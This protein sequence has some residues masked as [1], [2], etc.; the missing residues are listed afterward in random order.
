[1][2]KNECS[3][4]IFFLFFFIS[5]FFFLF[6]DSTECLAA[7]QGFFI[8]QNQK[9]QLI[10]EAVPITVFTNEDKII[11]PGNYGSSKFVVQNNNKESV[12]YE[13][14]VAT[15]SSEDI[16]LPLQFT[17]KAKNK[18]WFLPVSE[19]NDSKRELSIKRT[20]L[21][22][23]SE[24]F[25]LSWQWLNDDLH[26]QQIQKIVVNKEL[27]GIFSFK[28]IAERNKKDQAESENSNKKELT[29]RSDLTTD[30]HQQVS[31]D[32]VKP[33]K[34]RIF[35]RLGEYVYDPFAIILCILL[36]SCYWFRKRQKL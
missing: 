11:Y 35:P 27:T 9:Q 34:Q 1:M 12:N 10:I 18:E 33:D 25:I 7:D 24:E 26:D 30:S 15:F 23:E 16:F 5:L 36:F 8:N 6:P 29:N 31:Q 4:A 2:K 20:I 32:S 17:L 22:S 19:T 21:P 28:L 3:M 13:L 14:I